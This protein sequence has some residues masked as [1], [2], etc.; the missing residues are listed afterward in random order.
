MPR[1]MASITLDLDDKWS[2]LKTHGDATW[3]AM[4]SF[5]HA[6]VPRMLELLDEL[7]IRAT[8]FVVGMDAEQGANRDLLREIC[9]RGHE[10]GNHSHRHEPWL[11]RY[12]DA[13]IRD[14][15]RRAHDAIGIATETAPVG[16]RGPGYSLSPATL[17]ALGALGYHYDS[18]LLPT[19][20]GPLARRWY[21]R[22]ADFDESAHREREALFGSWR[23]G[24]RPLRPFRWDVDGPALVELPVTTMPVTRLPIHATYLLF[25]HERSPSLAR[26]Y[27]RLALDLCRARGVGPTMLLH[28]L[29]FLDPAD[30]D[31]R[32]LAF[33]PGVAQPYA[34]KRELLVDLLRRMDAAF[35]LA[36]L[37]LRA[38]ATAAEDLPS[39][40][41]VLTR[42]PT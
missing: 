36:P 39:K 5:L 13:E 38:Q 17:Q 2:Y 18:S 4:P 27:L 23:D 31:A 8:F 37:G 21:L 7:Q 29:E 3:T 26:A 40:V 12:S 19:W 33:L 42:R 41:P 14:E 11:H 9:V 22:S 10:V 16:F 28:P 30:E 20:I 35:W 24:L 6:V 25:L 32:G 15:L 1:P 34:A